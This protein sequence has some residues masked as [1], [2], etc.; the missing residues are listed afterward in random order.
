M[1][2]VVDRATRA[3]DRAIRS[4]L[5][6]SAYGHSLRLA[7]DTSPSFFD[8]T[9]VEGRLVDVVVA[10][11]GESVIGV[12]IRAEKQA[13][14]NGRP[15][16]VGYLGL[17]R[18]APGYRAGTLMA[19]GFR[20]IREFHNRGSARIYL[21]VVAEDSPEAL[22]LLES[23]RCGLP[24]SRDLGRLQTFVLSSKMIQ[25][26]GA[27]TPSLDIYLAGP[28]D[29]A[30]VVDLLA[31]GRERQFFPMY[32]EQDLASPGGLLR[33]LSV[34]D[35]LV[36]RREGVL[37]GVMGCWDQRPFRRQVVM[38]Y[39][40]KTA[41]LR[42]LYNLAAPLH[43]HPRLPREGTAALTMIVGPTYIPGADSDVLSGLLRE[44]AIKAT[45]LGLDSLA[46]MA[47]ES[48]PLNAL[49]QPL[50]AVRVDSRLL[51]CWYE[52]GQDLADTV[53]T[54]PPYLE[55]GSL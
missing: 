23:G 48:D 37:V 24:Q 46:I 1:A 31:R 9:S 5:S 34:N 14:V 39:D 3:D 53:D 29:A 17:L 21:T 50:P 15:E 47:H 30:D 10:R 44:A 32:H 13:F 25:R 2:L 28:D 40:R 41:L 26:R 35:V 55:L 20:R 18:I 52:D 4:Y 43:G 27:L 19:R 11:D 16:T 12:G 33:G 36:C 49:L 6:R 7:V 22:R 8:A 38:G 51:L 42:P 45:A 54:R